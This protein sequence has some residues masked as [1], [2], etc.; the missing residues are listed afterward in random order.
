M[1]ETFG[2]WDCSWTSRLRGC[3]TTSLVYD[4]QPSLGN[5]LSAHLRSWNDDWNDVH[6]R[7]NGRSTHVCRG[8]LYQVG[9]VGWCRLRNGES[10][11]RHFLGIPTWISGWAL[12]QPSSMD[13]SL[14]MSIRFLVYDLPRKPRIG[15]E[16][17]PYRN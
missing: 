9:Q 5:G 8:A 6:D 16:K 15:S 4:T 10:L 7:R 2:H 3:S 17:R 11:L 14:V 1:L 13:S 12:Y